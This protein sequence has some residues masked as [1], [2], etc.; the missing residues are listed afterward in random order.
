M[1]QLVC[2]EFWLLLNNLVECTTY[3]FE[4][5]REVSLNCLAGNVNNRIHFRYISCRWL[6]DSRDDY[7]YERLAE[8]QNKWSLY[9]CHTIM[10][11]TE[12]CPKGLNPGLAIGEIK[13]MLIY[14]N[15]YKHKKPET[16][17]V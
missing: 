16:R 8:F 11:C 14:F 17:T 1:L 3:K 9:R 15:Q 6:V 4:L 7:T 2:D 5:L 10:N 12:T 13:K